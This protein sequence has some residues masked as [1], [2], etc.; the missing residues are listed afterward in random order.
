MNSSLTKNRI[1]KAIN[2]QRT[3]KKIHIPTYSYKFRFFEDG[4]DK[5]ID[6]QNHDVDFTDKCNSV[7]SPILKI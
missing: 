7:K 2:V 5:S 3:L 4:C 1:D 6:K